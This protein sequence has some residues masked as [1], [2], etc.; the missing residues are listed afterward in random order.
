M[1][2]HLVYSTLCLLLICLLPQNIHS[3]TTFCLDKGDQL[4]VGYNQDSMNGQG[5]IIVNKRNVSKTAL[6]DQETACQPVK[7]T[8][9]YGSV[10][11]TMG[12]RDF[13]GGG[14]NEA[15][16][17]IHALTL[18]LSQYPPTDSRQCISIS[19]W[20]QYQLDNFDK[21]EQVIASDSQNREFLPKT[22]KQSR[23]IILFVIVRATVRS[24][25]LLMVRRFISQKK[26]CLSKSLAMTDMMSV[27][28]T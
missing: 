25:S 17:V 3:C 24:L 15:G 19:Q 26:Q 27:S 4:V 28:L 18:L 14:M 2:I 21:V 11:F 5:T 22:L 12:G 23:V 10:T 9:K 20:V 16:L 7:W 6:L 8:S 1:K 13:S